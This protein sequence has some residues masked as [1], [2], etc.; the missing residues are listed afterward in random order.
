MTGSG[1][2]VNLAS[3]K[4]G[5]GVVAASDELFGEKENLLR[6]GPPAAYPHTFGHK[7]KAVDGWET[8]RRRGAGHDFAL[9]RLGAAG[10]I[11]AVVADTAHF[12]G[13]YPAECSVEAC[14]AEGYPGP[15][16]LLAPAVEWVEIVPRTALAG[17]TENTFAVRDRRRFTHLRLNIYPDGGV[18]R[19]RAHGEVV[20]DPRFLG[21][22]PLDLVAQENGGTVLDASDRF[23]ADPENLIAPGRARVMSDGWETRRRRESG[24]DWVLF[25]LAAAG[26]VRQIVA[27]TSYF[28]GNAP[29][30]CAVRACDATVTG[31]AEAAWFDLLRTPLRADTRHRFRV[32]DEL[33]ARR[34]THVRL[35]IYPDGGLARLRL[36]GD[37]DAEGRSGLGLRWFDRLPAGQA[38]A[39]LTG[40]CGLTEQ[41]AAELAG[42]RPYER[43][44]RLEALLGD[45]GAAGSDAEAARRVRTMI[46]GS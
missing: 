34:V 27:D 43:S 12:T 15:G 1:V 31:L 5:A 29:S 3:R 36:F 18:A 32:A 38:A 2:L 39:V 8:R 42:R 14:A 20:P 25:R 28:V 24:N 9:I 11:H 6:P 45:G 41:A 44:D 7:G 23:Y 17:D 19:L 30:A 21:G 13:N 46:L 10:I 4:L 16:D 35:E 40:E 22:L 33:A 26:H 37:L